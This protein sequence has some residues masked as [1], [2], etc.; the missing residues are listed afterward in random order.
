MNLHEYCGVV[1]N[2]LAGGCTCLR[3]LFA[4]LTQRF[5][6]RKIDTR[7]ALTPAGREFGPSSPVESLGFAEG[8]PP[9]GA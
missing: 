6:M 1:N 4:H 5:E 2:S 3:E 8:P 9:Q 7:S